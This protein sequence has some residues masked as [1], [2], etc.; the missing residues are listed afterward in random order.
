MRIAFVL[1]CLLSVGGLSAQQDCYLGVGG[2]D[3]QTI[4]EVFRLDSLQREQLANLGAELKF[5]NQLLAQRA[6]YLLELHA[7]SSPEDLLVMSFEYRQVLDSMHSNMRLI[8]K[9][10]LSL[11]N[12]HSTTCIS[13]SAIRPKAVPFT[14]QELLPDRRKRRIAVRLLICF[15]FCRNCFACISML[16]GLYYS[17][18]IQSSFT[19]LLFTA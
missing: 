1:L 11:F 8:D 3:D 13:D 18:L 12:D 17:Y 14:R 10:L 2:P 7:Q 15:Y 4:T 5:R 19:T 9:K 6:E 16:S